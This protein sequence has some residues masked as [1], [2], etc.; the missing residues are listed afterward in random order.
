MLNTLKTNQTAMQEKDTDKLGGGYSPLASGLYKAK[1]AY[2][3]TTVSK[4]GAMG[5]VT[6]F[7]VFTSDN[8]KPRA[9]N[10]TF[11]VS[12]RNGETFYTDKDGVPHNL[13][14]FNTLN[15]LCGLITGKSLIECETEERQINLYNV[16]AKKELP[17]SVS[18]IIDL[19]DADVI[20][21]IKQ[22]RTNKQE[23]NSLGEYVDTAEERVFSEIDKF[24]IEKNGNVLTF[25]ELRE[26][27][28]ETN[29]ANE[30]ADKWTDKVDNRYKEVKGGSKG[31]NGGVA[32]KIS[33]V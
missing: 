8:D 15:Q 10:Q 13:P 33:I 32:K 20:L 31:S 22:I 14:D 24:F 9:L 26:G 4:G 2:A 16:D 19:L 5:V 25:N 17:T 23:K 18:C 12:N 3:Y 27:A 21:G 30:W 1:I 6:K 11:W 7:N 29:F 28:T